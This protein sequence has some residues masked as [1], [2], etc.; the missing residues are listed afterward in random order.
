MPANNVVRGARPPGRVVRSDGAR[1]L[2][3]TLTAMD[4]APGEP[5]AVADASADREKTRGPSM[6]RSIDAFRMPPRPIRPATSLR[7]RRPTSSRTLQSMFRR[8]PPPIR[9]RI[10]RP[11]WLRT[12]R[13]TL[14]APR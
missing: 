4:A 10:R 3:P 7:R 5:S 8:T 1:E 2:D 11:T 13:A 6:H 9:S 14:V 12:P